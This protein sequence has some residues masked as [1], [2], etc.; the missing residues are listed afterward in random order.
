MRILHVANFN[1]PKYG[2]DLYST[3]RKI[4]IGLIQNGH[5]VYDFSYRDICR[6][7]SFF[8]TTKLGTTAVNK[9]LIDSCN[10]L[11]PHLL[12]L[13]HSE[14]IEDETLAIIK[15]RHPDIK[16]GLWY[17]DALFHKEK[18]VHVR[19]RLQNIDTFFATTSGRYLQEYETTTTRA[20]F[21]PNMVTPAIESFQ[22]FDNPSFENDFI[23]CGRDTNDPERHAFLLALKQKTEKE[24]RCSFKGCLGNNPITGYAYL[25]FLSRAKMGLNISRRNDITLYSSDR[26]VQLTGNGLLT[27]CPKIP[28]MNLL[29]SDR[30]IIY[31]TDLDDLL[32]KL[33][34][35]HTHTEKRRQI[36]SAGWQRVHSSYSAVRV[37]R[38]M[39]E[40]LFDQP[41]SSKYEWENTL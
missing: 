19:K 1:N 39:L 25:Y 32:P 33:V 26:I 41:L 6:S 34:Y 29:F 22:A 3:D 38:Y 24:M 18:T 7:E 11:H 2:T 35:Y 12:L 21:I 10:N 36:A 30:E 13:G 28:K 9:R 31:F 5:F 16:I 37:T 23:F 14:L 4:S 8:R 27:F 15:H 20:A 40:K 17:V